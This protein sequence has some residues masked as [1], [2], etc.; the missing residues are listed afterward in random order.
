MRNR[1]VAALLFSGLLA[2]IAMA[3]VDHAEGDE[4]WLVLIAFLWLLVVVI[5]RVATMRQVKQTA[6][7][8]SS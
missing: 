1:R 7:E 3:A 2:A 5:L 4:A 8:V 6:T